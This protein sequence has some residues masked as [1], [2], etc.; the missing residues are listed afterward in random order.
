MSY[1]L[2][3]KSPGN[4]SVQGEA[5]KKSPKIMSPA[6]YPTPYRHMD[7]SASL[8]EGKA[9]IWSTMLN[10]INTITGAGMLGLPYAFANSGVAMGLLW[11]LLTGFGESYAIHL[12]G[13]C[14]LKERKFSFRALV[15]KTLHFK[16]KENFV[17]GIMA[18]NCFGYC[19]GYVIVCGQMFPD[20]VKDFFSIES[21]SI[22][23]NPVFWISIMVWA[24]A[25][26]LVCLRSLDNLKFT[27]AIGF[28]GIL[29]VAIITILY[30]FGEEFMGNA[31]SGHDKPCPGDF[32]WVFPGSVS[33]LLRVI[34]VFCYAFVCTQ[35][36][37]T[38]TFEMKNK[39]IRQLDLA[40][41]GAIVFAIG[42]YFLTALS[43]YLIFGSVVDPDM[44]VSFPRNTYISVAR[45]MIALV[46][47]TT[48][49]LQMFPTKDAVCNIIFGVDASR[50]K[51][52]QYYGT[53]FLL[54]AA[55]WTV[56]IFIKDLS[57]VLAFIGGTA[58]IF[59]GYTLPAFLY[60]RLFSEE[61]FTF[62]KIMSFIILFTSMILSPLLVV[63]EIYS[64]VS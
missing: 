24:I 41:N 12:L 47:C 31:C 15:N 1:A 40:V 18:F 32:Y 38:L 57:I 25:F 43:G 58:S 53:V 33:D 64:L 59:I 52:W 20:I 6:V 7:A 61:G 2:L 30:A 10:L 44:L 39:T 35:N 23:I 3:D 63:V 49:P 17:N 9:S 22:F 4:I 11:F 62:D 60:I 56:G 8:P 14:I 50:C 34:S 28:V 54:M 51:N 29:Y 13:K 21:S 27:S 5:V 19:C 46:L 16:G 55:A 36:V 26:P 42:I 48:F 45:L 37:P